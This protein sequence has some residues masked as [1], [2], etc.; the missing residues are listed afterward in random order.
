M[1]SMAW[2]VEKLRD[3]LANAEKRARAAAAAN[4]GIFFSLAFLFSFSFILCC[5]T[6]LGT[7]AIGCFFNGY[8]LLTNNPPK[9]LTIFS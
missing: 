3:E 9:F 6:D 7:E 2:E 8:F 5:Q 4:P 1:I